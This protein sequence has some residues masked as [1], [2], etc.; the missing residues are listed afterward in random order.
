VAS[1]LGPVF[2][3]TTGDTSFVDSE[4]V[5]SI[6][7]LRPGMPVT[8]GGIVNDERRI[9]A[10]TLAFIAEVRDVPVRSAVER[11]RASDVGLEGDVVAFGVSP[12]GA[13]G[14][15][16]VRA[17]SGRQYLVPVAAESVADLLQSGTVLGA[18]VRV[19]DATDGAFALQLL[20]EAAPEPSS[21]PD[22]DS[23]APPGRPDEPPVDAP[24]LVAV[25]GLVLSG[26]PG[27]ITVLTLRGRVEVLLS[28][29]SR[30]VPAG[31]GIFPDRALQGAPLVGRRVAL[32]GGL[33]PSTGE[34]LANVLVIGR[35]GERIAPGR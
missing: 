3:E 21:T 5:A 32:R 4:D 23:T 22:P 27:R 11:F 6:D 26:E 33:D 17:S 30:I 9:A 14:R 16:V 1:A 28:D 10:R 34:V 2:V 8:V 25:E 35:M 7:D 31:S 13:A 18:P 24:S 15:A 29:E 12:D 20:E 19:A